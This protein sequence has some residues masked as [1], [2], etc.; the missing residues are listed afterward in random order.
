MKKQKIKAKPKKD[1][2]KKAKD[3]KKYCHCNIE[4][5]WRRNY[6][7]YLMMMKKGKMDAPSKGTSELLIIKSNLM[8][9]SSSSW[10]LDSGSNAHLCMSMQDL[11]EIKRLR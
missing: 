2:P 4:G 5:H 3:K 11:E 10:I 8:I 1:I 7:A 9:F 6:L